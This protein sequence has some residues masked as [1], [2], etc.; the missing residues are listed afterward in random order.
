MFLRDRCRRHD[1]LGTNKPLQVTRET[2][3]PERRRSASDGPRTGI[4]NQ[5]VD[6]ASI[7]EARQSQ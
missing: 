6:L 1:G 3:A 5:R 2:R 4:Q 7:G